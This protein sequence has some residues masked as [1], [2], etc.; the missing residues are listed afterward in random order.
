MSE[1]TCFISKFL[2]TDNLDKQAQADETILPYY[3]GCYPANVTPKGVVEKCCWIWN[4]D[5][6]DKPG[7]HWVAVVKEDAIIY[8]FDSYGKTPYWFKRYYWEKYFSKLKCQMQLYNTNQIQSHI[9]RT[10]GSWCLLF[11]K[12]YYT[13]THIIRSSIFTH[14]IENLLQNEKQLQE[15]CYTLF[16]TLK[17]LYQ[18]KCKNN[19]GQ[20]CKSYVEMYPIIVKK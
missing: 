2:D 17:K 8:F 13:K 19:K 6:K 1:L 18:R 9:S 5:E 20:I 14:K 15:T 12:T 10:C 16:P 4:V 7:S 3:L 11:L